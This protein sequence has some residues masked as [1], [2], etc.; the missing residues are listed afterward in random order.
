[1]S[2]LHCN[3]PFGIG[4]T[5]KNRQAAADWAK[6]AIADGWDWRPTYSNQKTSEGEDP[7]LEWGDITLIKDGFHI[8]MYR[9][10]S[11]HKPPKLCIEVCGWGPDK[12]AFKVPD[13]YDMEKIK[14]L[15][16]ICS[17]CRTTGKTVRIGFAGRVC[18]ACRKKLKSKI[19]FPGWC[20]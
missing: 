10:H 2:N 14:S 4:A 13:E 8:A 7:S 1:M 12:L 16:E 18:P 6:A 15:M 17:E 11:G 5:E 9:R 19:E 3:K 20:D